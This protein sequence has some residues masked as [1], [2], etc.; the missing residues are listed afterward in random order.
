MEGTRR[1]TRNAATAQAM[2]SPSQADVPRPNSS[3][4]TSEDLVAD[5]RMPEM[6]II[7]FINVEHPA[8]R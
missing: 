8:D 5:A 6:E 7:S 3:T 4:S 2:P 1:S